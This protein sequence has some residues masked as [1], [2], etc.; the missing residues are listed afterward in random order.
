MGRGLPR[1]PFS[2]RGN[3]CHVVLLPQ[4][5]L[6]DGQR[7]SLGATRG[8]GGPEVFGAPAGG[9]GC[10]KGSLWTLNHVPAANPDAGG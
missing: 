10:W 3:R 8:Q 7:D 1:P 5:S 2:E 9:T 4:G 6:R